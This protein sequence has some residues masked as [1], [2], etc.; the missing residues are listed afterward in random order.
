M[1]YICAAQRRIGEDYAR[2]RGLDKATCV[3]LT[4]ARTLSSISRDSNIIVVD[5]P[6]SWPQYA[7]LR[8]TLRRFGNVFHDTF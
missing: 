6:H 7:E 3:F 8:N 2:A 4:E 5:T 1:R